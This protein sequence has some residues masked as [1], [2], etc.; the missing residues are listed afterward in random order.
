MVV[1]MHS[2][3]RAVLV[4]YVFKTSDAFKTF[5]SMYIMKTASTDLLSPAEFGYDIELPRYVQYPPPGPNLTLT[6]CIPHRQPPSP[7]PRYDLW[8][9]I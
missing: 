9:L 1:D 6:T 5:V 4:A 3:Q 8:S 2:L 7:D